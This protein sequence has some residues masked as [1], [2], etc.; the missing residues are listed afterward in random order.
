MTVTFSLLL[1]MIEFWQADTEGAAAASW[2]VPE[3]AVWLSEVLSCVEFEGRDD[4]F[5]APAQ[6]V[7]PATIIPIAKN[8]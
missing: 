8:L 4:S 1:T 7:S 2:A 3:D 5:A 6:P